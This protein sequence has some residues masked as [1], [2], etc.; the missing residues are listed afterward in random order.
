VKIRQNAERFSAKVF[1]E[2]FPRFVDQ[3]YQEWRAERERENAR[4]APNR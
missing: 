2:Q 3:A 1:R 4:T